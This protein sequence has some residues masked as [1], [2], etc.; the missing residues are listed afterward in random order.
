MGNSQP[1]EKMFGILKV[2]SKTP[3]HKKIATCNKSIRP[4][5][6]TIKGRITDSQLKKNFEILEG[7]ITDRRKG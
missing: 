5:Y 2:A 4:A 3:S 7:R 6:P 1:P